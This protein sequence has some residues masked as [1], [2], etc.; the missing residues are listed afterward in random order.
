MVLEDNF[1]ERREIGYRAK[2]EDASP[3]EVDCTLEVRIVEATVKSNSW[4]V[5]ETEDR[6]D[7]VCRWCPRNRAGRDSVSEVKEAA[8]VAV[9]IE[10]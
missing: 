1:E 7:W 9:A 2:D 3:L 6:E 5:A 8:Q 4:L 10:P